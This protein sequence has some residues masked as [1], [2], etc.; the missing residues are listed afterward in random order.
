MLILQ[1]VKM[2]CPTSDDYDDQA[3][4]NAEAVTDTE[5]AADKAT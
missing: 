5:A 4:Y 1:V 3:D 2:C